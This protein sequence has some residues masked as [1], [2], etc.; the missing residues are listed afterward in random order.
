MNTSHLVA[1]LF[2]ALTMVSCRTRKSEVSEISKKETTITD[3]MVDIEIKGDTSGS[4]SQLS[5]K[6]GKIVLGP[7]IYSEESDRA[8]APIISVDTNGILKVKCPC[9]DFKT[10]AKVTDTNTKSTSEKT[11]KIPVNY[12]TQWQIFQIWLGRI[13]LGIGILWVLLLILKK[14]IPFFR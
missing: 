13:L 8:G 11:I 7:V 9:L 10:Q 12:V 4:A 2:V 1:L 3:R 5:V 14:R 6:D